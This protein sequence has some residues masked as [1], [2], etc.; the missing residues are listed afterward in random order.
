M[1]KPLIPKTKGPFP[2]FDEA[3][4]VV[5]PIGGIVICVVFGPVGMLFVILFAIA[6]HLTGRR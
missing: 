1:S 5:L 6:W 2:E 4:S 3:C